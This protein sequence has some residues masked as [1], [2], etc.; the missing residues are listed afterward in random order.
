MRPVVSAIAS[1]AALAPLAAG[2]AGCPMP[3]SPA[4][5]M[6]EAAIELNTNTRFGRMELAIER[7]APAARDEFIA[8]RKGWGNAL[9]LADYEMVGARMNDEDNAEVSVKYAWYRPD[10]NDLHTTIVRQKWKDT[11]GAWL[12]VAEARVDGDLGLFGEAVAAPPP[13]PRENVQFPTV[14]FSGE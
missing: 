13:R 12:L 10:D 8:H 4:A 11:K 3:P 7:V 14:R 5:R 9:Q 6:Q 2:L 1:L